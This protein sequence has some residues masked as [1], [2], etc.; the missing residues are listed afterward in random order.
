MLDHLSIQCADIRRQRGVLR[1][2]ARATRRRAHHGLRSSHRVRRAADARLLDRSARDRR[3]LHRVAHRLLRTGPR[4]RAG[5][6]RRRGRAPAPRCCTNRGCGPN[7]TPTTTAPS[8]ATP[9]A[10]TSR[11]CV[12]RR[13]DRPRRRYEAIGNVVSGPPSS[14]RGATTTGTGHI[15][16]SFEN[17]TASNP[18]RL[19]GTITLV[20]G[21]R[22]STW[23]ISLTASAP[24]VEMVSTSSVCGLSRHAT[25]SR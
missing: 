21:C 8:S 11:R 2:S 4:G 25:W 3:G 20:T 24:D 10:T 13:S 18:G 7:T 22:C 15:R 19:A 23:K 6:L 17:P 5:V 16:S 1:R 12:T 14:T 9:T